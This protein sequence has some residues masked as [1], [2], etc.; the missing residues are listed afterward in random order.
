MENDENVKY[1][2][3]FAMEIKTLKLEH[4][5]AFNYKLVWMTSN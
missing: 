3:V 4:K 2:Y 1:C 5:G